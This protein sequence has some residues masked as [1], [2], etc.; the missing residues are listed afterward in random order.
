MSAWRI[1]RPVTAF[2]NDRPRKSRGG[3]REDGGHLAFIR[4]LP[5]SVCAGGA[6]V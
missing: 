2:M 3:R 4:K 6:Y 1:Q 5:Y